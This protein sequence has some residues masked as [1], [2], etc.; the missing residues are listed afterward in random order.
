MHRVYPRF[1][2]GLRGEPK[3]FKIAY[4]SALAVCEKLSS[5]RSIAFVSMGTGVYKRP[6]EHTAKIAITALAKSRFDKT[7]MCLTSDNLLPMYKR[8]LMDHKGAINFN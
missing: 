6:P 3:D 2:G 4:L 1:Y 5:A 7:L 8:E